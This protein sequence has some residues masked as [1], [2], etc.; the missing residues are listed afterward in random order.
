MNKSNTVV[1][2]RKNMEIMQTFYALFTVLMEDETYTDKVR[3][4]KLR[5]L[6]KKLKNA[7]PG[8]Q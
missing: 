4:E 1:V 7:T 6:H 3:L 5:I 2:D 8:I